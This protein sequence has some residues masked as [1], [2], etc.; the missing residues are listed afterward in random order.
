MSAADALLAEVI[1]RLGNGIQAGPRDALVVDVSRK[2]R[3][4]EAFGLCKTMK[5][6]GIIVGT[7]AAIAIVHFSNRDYRVLFFCS[8]IP[9]FGGCALLLIMGKRNL[10]QF[11]RP[12]PDV[13]LWPSRS[14]LSNLL[15]P[16]FLGLMFLAFICELGHFTE[17]LLTIMASNLVPT[18][19]A[20][21]TTIVMAL[22]QMAFLYPMGLLADRKS[23]AHPRAT[24]V[25][26]PLSGSN[27]RL[28]ENEISLMKMCLLLSM[29][30][31]LLMANCASYACFFIGVFV[32]SGQQASLQ[33]LFLSVIGRCVHPRSTAT[34][35]GIFYSVI[36]GAY[37][38][39]SRICG[40]L[41][42]CS[43]SAYAFFYAAIM[44]VI[45]IYLCSMID[46]IIK[47]NPV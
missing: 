40:T 9:A 10:L 39:A 46:R 8:A 5:T 42:E 17:S 45:G 19:F 26:K 31:Y 35:V 15:E 20:G 28:P 11:K 24:S 3:V 1:E 43:G 13:P 14:G 12:L 41:W 27:S 33:L 21:I 47:K 30:S 44:C 29:L 18:A 34:A 37:M 23:S 2:E 6:I 38:I 36:G 16:R 25:L 7:A 4:G 22:G 32:V